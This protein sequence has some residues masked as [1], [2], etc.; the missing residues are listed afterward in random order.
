[1]INGPSKVLWLQSDN[2][3]NVF[4]V[5]IIQNALQ[6]YER[7]QQLEL[8]QSLPTVSLNLWCYVWLTISS[9]FEKNVL[10][11]ENISNSIDWGWL[12]QNT[13]IWT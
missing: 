2:I 7:P 1:M 13:F 10:K 4:P 12:R 6:K 8:Q 11:T 3:G 9:F 5:L